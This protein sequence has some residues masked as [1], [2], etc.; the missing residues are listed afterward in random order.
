MT[1]S[2]PAGV[3]P[4]ESLPSRP[5]PPLPARPTTVYVV[6]FAPSWADTPW[7]QSDSHYWGMNALHKLA[8]DQKWNAWF[9][10]HDIEEHHK[11]DME[12]HIKWLVSQP[13]PIYMW[14]EHVEKY[15]LPNA[16][17]YP[18]EL[19]VAKYGRYF[20]NTVSWM[21]AY[22]I[23][24]AFSKIGVYGVDMAQDSEYGNQRPSCEYFL[25]WARGVGIEIDIPPNSDL[26]KSP[27][28]YGYQ[29]GGMM[30]VKYKARLKELAERREAL[31]RQRNQ[32]H[33][34]ALQVM[35]AQ[36]DTQ[37][38]LRAWSQEEAKKNGDS[39]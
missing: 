36:E 35:G 33:E 24:A 21:I 27:W 17:P 10:L 20:T 19:I 7:E 16:V 22:A 14:E 29:D 13:M 30:T 9:Q 37:Y 12:E 11:E 1:T 38:W 8:P 32:A 18:R 4:S 31:E 6:G 15:Q 3:A 5:N 2:A 23:E 28:L 26:L 25:G 39:T 34:A